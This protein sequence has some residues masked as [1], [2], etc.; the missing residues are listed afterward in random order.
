MTDTLQFCKVFLLL[1]GNQVPGQIDDQ[2]NI[3]FRQIDARFK[4][5]QA[6]LTLND[7]F[8]EMADTTQIITLQP[9]S[10]PLLL[11]RGEILCY[12]RGRVKFK[13]GD[14]IPDLPIEIRAL[15]D[16]SQVLTT[17]KSDKDGHFNLQVPPDRC[18]RQYI[19]QVDHPQLHIPVRD[20][21]YPESGDFLFL[22]K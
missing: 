6:D 4:G 5:I 9:P 12:V 16:A 14:P 22:I 17:G 19:I 15:P 3:L 2:G 7:C 8:W 21:V 20:T 11:S 18:A 13:F 10:Q 1:E